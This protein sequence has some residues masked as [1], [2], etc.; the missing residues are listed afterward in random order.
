MIAVSAADLE[1]TERA[2]CTQVDPD[3]M[4]PRKGESTEDAKKVCRSCEARLDCLRFSIQVTDREGI[5]GGFTMRVRQ[6]IERDHRA[7][8]PLEDIIAEDDAKFYARLEKA[9]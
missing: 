3:L 5:Y 1:W 6:R 4:F 7:G 2:L 8:K 9:A